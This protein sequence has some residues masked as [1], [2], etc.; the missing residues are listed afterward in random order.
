MINEK[1]KNYTSSVP[2][3]RTIQRIDSILVNAGATDIM[4]N[5]VD[6]ELEAISFRIFRHN[7]YFAFKLPANVQGVSMA[8]YGKNYTALKTEQR[9]QAQRTAW[10][11]VQDWTELQITM[12]KLQQADIVQ[13][14]FTY[15]LGKDGKTVFEQLMDNN[16]TQLQLTQ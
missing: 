6:K 4:R 10:K 11:C 15:M 13:V 3:E 2:I 9:L 12:V 14:F 1:I 7:K 8:L 16:F 5:Y